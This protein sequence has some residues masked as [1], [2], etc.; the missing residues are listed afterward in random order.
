LSRPTSSQCRRSLA[1][2]HNVPFRDSQ[3]LMSTER[4]P[5]ACRGFRSSTEERLV[6]TRRF[7]TI[8]KH[9][10]GKARGDRVSHCKRR[11]ASMIVTTVAAPKI[12]TNR[13]SP[14]TAARPQPSAASA[15]SAASSRTRG[16]IYRILFISPLFW[17]RPDPPGVGARR[18]ETCHNAPSPDGRRD[19]LTNAWLAA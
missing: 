8:P 12:A 3:A 6:L 2:F 15:A 19:R 10:S 16:S 13:R 1:I 14:C 9:K 4:K 17:R 18:A 5:R 7:D 11:I